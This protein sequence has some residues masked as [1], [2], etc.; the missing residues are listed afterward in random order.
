MRSSSI[1]HLVAELPIVSS[2][3]STLE[4]PPRIFT[5]KITCSFASLW[6]SLRNQR[7]HL[8]TLSHPSSLQYLSHKYITYKPHLRHIITTSHKHLNHIV[9][10]SKPNLSHISDISQILF[11]LKYRQMYSASQLH[12]R[13]ISP[14]QPEKHFNC[15]RAKFQINQRHISLWL[16]PYYRQI[17]LAHLSSISVSSQLSKPNS[18]STRVGSDKVIGWPAHPAPPPT[19]HTLLRH[20]QS[21]QEADFRYAT[22][23]QPN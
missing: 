8:E 15:I 19:R 17:F 16:Q 3:S 7:A 14:S 5:L 4:E 22:L 11:K 2:G 6:G 23:F 21:T 10:T 13:R 12:L 9:A 20:F 1:F 18:T